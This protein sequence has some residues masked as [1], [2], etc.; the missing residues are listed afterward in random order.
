[1][2]K[3]IF[4]ETTTE[5]SKK[6]NITGE[7]Y[8]QLKDSFFPIEN[9]NDFVVVILVWWNKSADLLARSPVGTIANFS[10]MDGPFFVRG[11]KIGIDNVTLTFI[12]RT[13]TVEE[14]LYTID[15]NNHVLKRSI[16]EVSKRVLIIIKDKKWQLNDDVLELEKLV[17]T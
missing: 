4:N 17:S 13:S 11:K 9:W 2:I 7:L 14:V 12:R 16:L 15:V 6:G 5:I 1:M 3:I 8:F 10:F